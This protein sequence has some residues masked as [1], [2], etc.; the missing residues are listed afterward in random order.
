MKR[1]Y[2][3]NIDGTKFDPT[4]PKYKKRENIENAFNRSQFLDDEDGG[5]ASA[6]A[7]RAY[8]D[9]KLKSIRA[10]LSGDK[11]ME[12]PKNFMIEEAEKYVQELAAKVAED[13]RAHI[14]REIPKGLLKD[15]QFILAVLKK[16]NELGNSTNVVMELMPKE[17]RD[18]AQFMVKAVEIN[19]SNYYYASDRIKNDKELAMLAMKNKGSLG[20]LTENFRKDKTFAME[21]VRSRGSNLEWVPD[22]LKDDREIILAAVK[23]DGNALVYAPEKYKNDLAIVLEAVKQDKSAMLYVPKVLREKIGLDY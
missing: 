4:D 21:A 8:D 9:A 3:N 7:V 22:E 17:Y 12:D 6:E 15:K 5:F 14:I 13:E 2:V 23:N 1:E 16:A 10:V 20:D 18:D 11:T 19:G